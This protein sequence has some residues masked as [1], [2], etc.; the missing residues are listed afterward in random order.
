MDRDILIACAPTDD[1]DGSAIQVQNLDAAYP[2]ASFEPQRQYDGTWDLPIDVTKLQWESY[3]KAAYHVRFTLHSPSGRNPITS[4]Q[5]VL[6]HFFGAE[7]CDQPKGAQFLATGQHCP[8]LDVCLAIYFAPL[9]FCPV[10][11]RPL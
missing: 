4:S 11:R 6:S 7:G 1:T 3:V 9:R 10:G 2:T 8:F 5:G